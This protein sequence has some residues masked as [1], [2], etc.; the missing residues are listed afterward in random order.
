LNWKIFAN[1]KIAGSAGVPP[2]CSRKLAGETPA[3]PAPFVKGII[4][5]QKAAENFPRLDE[6][7]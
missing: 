7:L 3:L 2:A 1:A 6:N 5:P 4:R